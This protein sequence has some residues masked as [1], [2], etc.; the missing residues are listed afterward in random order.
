MSLNGVD[1]FSREYCGAL[2]QG[3]MKEYYISLVPPERQ[4][5]VALLM[6]DLIRRFNSSTNWVNDQ[7]HFARDLARI[8]DIIQN[9]N[10]SGSSSMVSSDP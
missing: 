8:D 6:D 2:I 3:G 5:E 10:S 7:V 4:G 1:P 9:T